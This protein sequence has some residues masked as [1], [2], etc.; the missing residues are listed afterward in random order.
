[1]NFSKFAD[2]LFRFDNTVEAQRRAELALP[3]ILAKSNLHLWNIGDAVLPHSIRFLIGVATW[4]LSDLRLLNALNAVLL[5]E[6]RTERV[7]VFNL[8]VCQT[9]TD[10]LAFVAN[11]DKVYQSPV[12]GVWYDGEQ[13][14][15]ACGY[16]GRQILIEHFALDKAKIVT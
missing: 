1:M 2:L 13:I 5:N 6:K 14:K 12:V 7:D 3:F 15:Q 9:Q 10:I 8:D 11:L 4:S 16:D